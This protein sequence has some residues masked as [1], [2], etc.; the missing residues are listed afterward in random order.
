MTHTT[1]YAVKTNSFLDF[2]STKYHQIE[3][4]YEDDGR[5]TNKSSNSH[6]IKSH[7][8]CELKKYTHRH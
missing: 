3:L 6:G 1:K 4:K 7:V 8:Y 2:N 5:E